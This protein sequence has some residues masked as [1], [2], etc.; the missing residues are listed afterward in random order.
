MLVEFTVGNY[1]SFRDDATLS[2]VA[3][4]LK[5]QESSTD[6][7]N[8]MDCSTGLELLRSAAV[9]GANAS[10]KSNLVRALRTMR[11]MVLGSVG[12]P[13][14]KPSLPAE[15]FLLEVGKDEDPCYF[16]IVLKAPE[17]RYRY[18]FEFTRSEIVAE[19]LYRTKKRETKLFMRE[20]QEFSMSATF[21]KEGKGLE[22]KTRSDTLFLS[23]CAQFNSA[24]A[25]EVVDWFWRLRV[26]SGINL[27]EA[28]MVTAV[29]I[30]N[31]EEQRA[32]VE[33]LLSRFDLGFTSVRTEKKSIDPKIQELIRMVTD[34]QGGDADT[35]EPVNISVYT[36]HPRLDENG[37]EVG[38]V[39][40][41][42]LRHESAGTQRLFELAGPFLS[43]LSNNF[44][45]VIDEF[46]A[47]LHPL[48]TLKLIEVFHGANQPD[49][50]AQMI[51]TTHDTHILDLKLFRR[52][53]IWFTE[54]TKMGNS[55]LYSLAEIKNVR[56][57]ASIDKEYFRG[58]YGGIPR[59]GRLA[60]DAILSRSDEESER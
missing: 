13:G 37:N 5:A 51:I 52:D 56:N 2:L 45:L 41:D 40:L 18:G 9:Y 26:V 39:D 12:R 60:A 29:G 22:D 27:R 16:E 57:D 25:M 1:R 46:T 59:L 10:G 14:H 58:R 38:T 47:R 32:S 53:Q 23:V 3:T 21:A 54:K 33:D 49:C 43:A 30:H 6:E 20:G 19:W 24:I 28:S 35:E 44:V 17:A 36:Q 11:E 48:L 42:M 15:P 34:V 8:V 31:N 7:R 50:R 4:K 55:T